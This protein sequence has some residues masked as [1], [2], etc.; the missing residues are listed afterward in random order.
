VR[1][2]TRNRLQRPWHWILN[3]SL[4]HD[5]PRTQR[6]QHYASF[7]QDSVQ[8]Y[9]DIVFWFLQKHRRSAVTA[10]KIT[11]PVLV[12]SGCK[13]RLIRPGVIR[14]IAERY[15]QSLLEWI[16]ERGHMLILGEEGEA[17]GRRIVTWLAAHN[18][19]NSL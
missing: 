4:L 7:V 11:C 8:C 9:I 13:D 6:P 3:L 17:I 10:D 19:K 12:L 15:P 1:I 14:K 2:V 18:K 16:P 5:L